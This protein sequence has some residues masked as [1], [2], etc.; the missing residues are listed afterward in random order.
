MTELRYGT[1]AEAGMLPERVA[2]ARGVAERLVKQGETPSL[3]VLAARR[4]VIF[5][6]EA[7]GVHGPE[8]GAAPLERDGLFPIASLS[9]PVTATLLMG[10]VED[11]LV[12]LNRPAVEYLPELCGEGT[13]EILVHHLLTHTSGFEEEA[14]NAFVV[15]RVLEG[16][17]FPPCPPT[18]H[19]VVN[20]VLALFWPAP[21]HKPPGQYMH[22]ANHNYELLGEIVR[23][24][25]GRAIDDL[26][27][28]RVFAPLGMTDS[29]YAVPESVEPRIVK[30]GPDA[31]QGQSLHKYMQGIDSR[32]MQE[33]PYA[34]AGMFSTARDLASFGQAFLCGGSYG[35]ARILSRP[36]VET[37]TR[38]QIPGIPAELA[39]EHHDEASWG[40]GW[41][42]ES[43]E[44]WI[45]Y[46]GSLLRPGTY[47]HGGGGG[48]MLWVDPPNQIVGVYL[49]V[50]KPGEQPRDEI[51]YLDLF[52]N[53]VTA[54]VED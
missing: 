8:A 37:M 23:R 44:K 31:A 18:Q 17:E 52:Q 33:T 2:L 15:P 39:G 3:I 45:G 11:G 36:S 43:H 53:A 26:A 19:P 50:A 29:Y 1:P 6:H 16:I 22:Y 34:G 47:N 10:L 35:S 14:L 38:N 4:G 54:A 27:R 5:L 46:D 30:R 13:Q 51:W 7:F 12:G 24:V 40:Y 9:K 20:E 21:V 49:S 41:G 42:I 32:Q 48:T 25:S 28:E